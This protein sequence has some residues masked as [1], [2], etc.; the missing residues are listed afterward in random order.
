MLDNQYNNH[1]AVSVF[2]CLH[3]KLWANASATVNSLRLDEN[4]FAP[5]LLWNDHIEEFTDL[6][7]N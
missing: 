3:W 5:V 6:M 7:H 2:V 4:C 1:I